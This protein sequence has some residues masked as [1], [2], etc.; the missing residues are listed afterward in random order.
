MAPA[1]AIRTGDAAQSAT[2]MYRSPQLL[3]VRSRNRAT[4][5]LGRLRT[6]VMP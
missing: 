3:R 6:I 2:T 4:S 1:P 5:A